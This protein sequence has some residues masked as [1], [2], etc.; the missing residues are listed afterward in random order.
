MRAAKIALK[1]NNTPLPKTW[2]GGGVSLNLALAAALDVSAD[3]VDVLS[4]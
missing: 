3:A 1:G 4:L 2:L